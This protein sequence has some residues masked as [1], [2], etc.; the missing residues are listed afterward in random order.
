MLLQVILEPKYL[1][2]DHRFKT[3]DNVEAAVKEMLKEQ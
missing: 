3:D 2:G 1:L